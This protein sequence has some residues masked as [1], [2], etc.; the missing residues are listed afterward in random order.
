MQ[1]T[2]GS[3]AAVWKTGQKIL[4]ESEPGTTASQQLNH[5]TIEHTLSLLFSGLKF[6][7]ASSYR[8]ICDFAATDK[9]QTFDE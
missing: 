8:R 3:W 7:L 1:L 5:N 4:E 2:S 9:L 6:V